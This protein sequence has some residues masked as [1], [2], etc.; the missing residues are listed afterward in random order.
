MLEASALAALPE[1][2]PHLH[3]QPPP[4]SQT[5]A[6]L[7]LKGRR[8]F[9]MSY[10][11]WG[12]R[13]QL[14]LVTGKSFFLFCLHLIETFSLGFQRDQT[15]ESVYFG[16]QQHFPTSVQP[17]E[18][19]GIS[20]ELCGAVVTSCRQVKGVHGPWWAQLFMAPGGR[21][22]LWPGLPCP[23]VASWKAS[24]FSPPWACDH[25]DSKAHSGPQIT[26]WGPPASACSS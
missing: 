26:L 10:C 9:A 17:A 5:R 22:V 19:P 6:E 18:T 13:R 8:Q 2:A 25:P 12:F 15:K 11:F 14:G 24:A 16:T 20:S 23:D 3:P 21:C 1:P 7:V 4:C